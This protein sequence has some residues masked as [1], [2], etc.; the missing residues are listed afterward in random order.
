M[1]RADRSVDCGRIGRYR[2]SCL[3]IVPGSFAC[4]S[5]LC[6]GLYQF[7]FVG[8]GPWDCILSIVECILV[9]GI[10]FVP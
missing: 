10:G 3:D 5:F 9:I 6:N 2:V 4:N 7:R 1:I 8:I